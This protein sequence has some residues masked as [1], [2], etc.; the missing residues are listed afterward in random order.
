MVYC[1]QNCLLYYSV[2]EN[3]FLTFEHFHT[4]LQESY[5]SFIM[6]K[7]SICDDDRIFCRQ[8]KQTVSQK[9]DGLK[10]PYTIPCHYNSASLMAG[11]M[12]FD[13][14]FLDIQMAGMDGISLA[15]CLR[16]QDFPGAIIFTTILKDCMLDAFEVEAID[17]LCKPIDDLRLEN[18]LKRT[19]KRHNTQNETGAALSVFVTFFIVK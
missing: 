18:A 17:Y 15:R 13:L 14:L 9:L 5:R 19:L 16:Q 10:E 12:D 7:I 6:I 1:P 8:L 11:P 4:A 3:L 2:S